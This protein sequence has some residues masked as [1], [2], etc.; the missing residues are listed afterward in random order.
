MA[1][2]GHILIYNSRNYQNPIDSRH[3]KTAH[4]IY[5]SRNYQNPIDPYHLL[6]EIL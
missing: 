6:I 5:N 1:F 4:H 3:N 2:K